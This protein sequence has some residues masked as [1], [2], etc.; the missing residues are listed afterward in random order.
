[1]T[2][3]STT[4][5][6]RTNPTTP[7]NPLPSLK[8][9]W[10]ADSVAKGESGPPP[11]SAAERGSSGYRIL[12]TAA[13][14]RGARNGW[15]HRTTRAARACPFSTPSLSD[16]LVFSLFLFRY[17]SFQV[18]LYSIITFGLLVMHVVHHCNVHRLALPRR[19]H[20]LATDMVVGSKRQKAV[21]CHAAAT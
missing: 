4:I 8:E 1:M 6:A 18:L 14:E 5:P 3:H 15:T 9:Q 17:S 13:G 21:H 12:S 7:T 11:S 19:A 20:L 2:A 10:S 16:A